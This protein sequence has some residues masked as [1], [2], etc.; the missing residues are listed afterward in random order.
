MSTTLRVVLMLSAVVTVV[1]ILRKIYKCKVKLKDAI[2]WFCM[3]ALLA[4]L[5]IAPQVAY[6]FASIMG[7]QAAANFIF[8]VVL[9]LAMEKLFTMSIIVSQLEDKITV[10]S[11]EVALRTHDDRQKIEQLEEEIK[12]YE[13]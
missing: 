1:W 7:F 6:G 8:L 4:L 3:A 11:A 9:A 2:F 12:K 13:K 10:L 5:G